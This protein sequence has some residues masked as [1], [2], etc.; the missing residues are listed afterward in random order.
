MN[1]KGKPKHAS[2]NYS[3]RKAPDTVQTLRC[4]PRGKDPDTCT[5]AF[6]CASVMPVFL[7][8]VDD[9]GFFV[10]AVCKSEQVFFRQTPGHI[11]LWLDIW[12]CVAS[13]P[14]DEAQEVQFRPRLFFVP[15][16]RGIGRK[17]AEDIQVNEGI[18]EILAVI[19]PRRPPQFCFRIQQTRYNSLEVNRQLTPN[20]NF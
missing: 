9:V 4:S 13:R 16:W 2:Q 20:Q 10:S 15:D 17:R 8:G 5:D 12:F 7:Q 1:R 19:A 18:A 3:H 11:E 6:Q 14:A